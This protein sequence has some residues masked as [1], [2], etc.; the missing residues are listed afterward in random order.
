M[1]T[2]EEIQSFVNDTVTSAWESRIGQKVPTPDDLALK[3]SAVELEATVLYA[4]LAGSTKM[5]AASRRE[6]AAEIYKSYLYCAS[7]IIRHHG[8]EITAYDGD[9]VMGVFIGT[10]K[11]TNAAKCALR[12]NWATQD[13]VNA[14]LKSYYKSPPV[15]E[16]RV[17]V[18]TSKLFVARTGIRGNNDLV[19]V[20]NAANNAAKLAALPPVYPS[21]ITAAVY[22]KIAEEAK[23]H[24]EVNMW[25]DLGS[26]QMGYQIYGSTY[27]WGL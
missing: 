21:Y 1:G 4:D 3:N 5:V 13:I 8:G 26:A 27:K 2:R 17:G 24:D 22:N 15:V 18:D 16:Q 25:K 14:N 7:K 19:W 6:V 10:S 11:N 20:G 9:R 12:I 23:F